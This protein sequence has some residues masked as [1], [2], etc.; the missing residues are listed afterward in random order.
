MRT[1]L[2]HIIENEDVEILRKAKE[3]MGV[4]FRAEHIEC[5][6]DETELDDAILEIGDICFEE[7]DLPI[8]TCGCDDDDDDDD[9][10][11]EA[12]EYCDYCGKEIRKGDEV[13]ET[14]S[15]VFCSLGCSEAWYEVDDY[16]DEDEDEDDE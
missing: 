11:D 9:D 7:I 2:V 14:N 6:C 15:G 5:E 16:E 10:E 13:I 4:A 12:V 3:I 8:C 1:K